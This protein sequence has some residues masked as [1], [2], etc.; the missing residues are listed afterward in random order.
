MYSVS[1]ILVT[2]KE[3]HRESF[4]DKE[5]WYKLSTVQFAKCICINLINVFSHIAKCIQHLLFWQQEE[6]HRESFLDKEVGNTLL[7]SLCSLQHH[8][9]ST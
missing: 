8:L 1:A 3:V 9:L 2:Q 6:V 5:V 4:P 7:P